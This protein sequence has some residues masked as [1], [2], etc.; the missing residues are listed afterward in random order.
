MEIAR[1]QLRID[2]APPGH[3]AVETRERGG[4][5]GADNPKVE[6]SLSK[7]RQV[8]GASEY[9]AAVDLVTSVI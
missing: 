4:R 2:L 7:W 3:I 9:P 6:N 8:M 5:Y 1:G